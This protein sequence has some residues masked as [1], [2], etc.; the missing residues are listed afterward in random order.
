MSQ[1]PGAFEMLATLNTPRLMELSVVDAAEKTSFL[2]ETTALAQGEEICAFTRTQGSLPEKVVVTGKLN[3]KA[4]TKTLAV[5]DVAGGAGYLPR[6]WAKLEID[7]LLA[8]GADKNK[9]AVIDLSMAMYVMTPF[10]SLLVLEK[11]EDYATYKVDRGRKDHWAMYDSPRRIPTVYE[12]YGNQQ[13][14]KEAEVK[15]E[16]APKEKKGKTVTDVLGTILVRIP[17]SLLVMPGQK[18]KQPALVVNASDWL[19]MSFR[20]Q[21]TGERLRP[22]RN[23]YLQMCFTF[24]LALTRNPSYA[25][26]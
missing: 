6:T 14:R 23:F 19:R 13:V 2:T 15:T 18:E 20:S 17:P 16:P 7:R 26:S 8:D 3:G 12:P 5:K 10:T 1:L 21:N 25:V 22:G 4:F 11:D 9:K 24:A